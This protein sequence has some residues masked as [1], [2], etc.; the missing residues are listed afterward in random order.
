M[1]KEIPETPS[2]NK[3][4]GSGCNHRTCTKW[5]YPPSTNIVSC[6]SDTPHQNCK[7]CSPSTGRGENFDLQLHPG[8]KDR[9]VTGT[10]TTQPF[11]KQRVHCP[12]RPGAEAP[13]LKWPSSKVLP[14]KHAPPSLLHTRPSVP[15]PPLKTCHLFPLKEVNLGSLGCLEILFPCCI[16]DAL[17]ITLT[18]CYSWAITIY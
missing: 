18:V 5:S 6:F 8:P 14:L 15:P 3:V 11:Q 16:L 10:W 4:V 17:A 13:Y 1:G 12:G 9:D 2:H 7:S